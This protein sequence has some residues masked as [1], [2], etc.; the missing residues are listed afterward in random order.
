MNTMEN[1]SDEDLFSDDDF[2]DLEFDED[3]NEE[4][5]MDDDD[6]FNPEHIWDTLPFRRYRFNPEVWCQ[7]TFSDVIS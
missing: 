1:L 5:E 2:D 6:I 3:Y 4:F 7:L